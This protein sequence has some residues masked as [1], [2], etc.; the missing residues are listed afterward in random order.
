M[1]KTSLQSYSYRALSAVYRSKPAGKSKHAEAGAGPE[2]GLL[3]TALAVWWDSPT[4]DPTSSRH[5][6]PL[7]G[8]VTCGCLL[9]LL[10]CLSIDS[11]FPP[12]FFILSWAMTPGKMLLLLLFLVSASILNTQMTTSYPEITELFILTFSAVHNLLSQFFYINL[13]LSAIINSCL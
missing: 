4:L 3:Q 8:H 12:V 7:S 10:T 6:A 13:P 5:Q 9:H 1:N 2:Q 11:L